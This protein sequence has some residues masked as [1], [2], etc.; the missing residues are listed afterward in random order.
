MAEMI[1]VD[2]DGDGSLTQNGNERFPAQVSV[3]EKDG[4]RRPFRR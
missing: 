2:L 3:D 1:T 4:V